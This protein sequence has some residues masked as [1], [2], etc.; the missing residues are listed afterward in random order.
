MNQAPAI[1]HL[2]SSNSYRQNTFM[3]K[4]Y[5]EDW[6][7]EDALREVLQNQYDGIISLIGKAN[8]SIE[9]KGEDR[10]NAFEFEFRHKE[11]GDLYGEIKYNPDENY[12]E[13]EVWNIGSLETADLLLGGPK[14]EEGK[15]NKEII[16]RF[17]EGMK[18]AALAF[19]KKDIQYKIITSGQEWRFTLEKDPKFTRKGVA[20]ECLFLYRKN[21]PVEYIDEYKNKVTVIISNLDKKTWTD[22]IDDFLWLTQKEMGKVP[23]EVNGE[24]IG[25]VLLG[26][27][28]CYKNYVKE[29]YVDKIG[30]NFGLNVNIDLD[31]DR[32]CIPDLNKRNEEAHKLITNIL[33]NL[34]ESNDASDKYSLKYLHKPEFSEKTSDLLREFPKRIYDSLYSGNGITQYLYTKFNNQD[35]GTTLIFNEWEKAWKEKGENTEGKQPGYS[36]YIYRFLNE[37]KLD[38]SFYPFLSY[39]NWWLFNCMVK[40]V[41]YYSVETKF[42]DY[43]KNSIISEVPNDFRNIISSIVQKVKIA[44]NDFNENMMKFKKYN[45]N[46]IYFVYFESGIIY[47][48][49]ALFKIPGKEFANFVFSKCLELNGINVRK[50]V[51]IYNLI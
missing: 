28:F 36:D 9:P 33:N 4:N 24:V 7:P 5:I 27:K 42:S 20:Q 34:K 3:S 10:K 12:K 38:S 37:R 46:D 8:I 29:I 44:K 22:K 47:F 30:G 48:S 43:T 6:K 16:G 31:R 25:E 15:K 19:L 39:N 18:L 21:L 32:N 49:D 45:H 50:I 17:G 41:R 26:E 14:Y 13:L 2:S 35:K 1:N 51:E 11:T 23:V 40:S